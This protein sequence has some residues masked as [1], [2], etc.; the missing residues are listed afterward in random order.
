MI[1]TNEYQSEILHTIELLQ[2]DAAWEGWPIYKALFTVN[3][4]V[5]AD[6]FWR[7]M[8]ASCSRIWGYSIEK[9]SAIQKMNLDYCMDKALDG[10][11]SQR[12]E[13]LFR[14]DEK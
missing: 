6:I 7:E 9:S 13:R 5:M 10:Y 8:V 12:I 2:S 3:S 14:L 1:E 11:H 4:R